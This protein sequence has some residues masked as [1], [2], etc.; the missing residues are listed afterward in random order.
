MPHRTWIC[1]YLPAVISLLLM[2]PST[3]AQFLLPL[4]DNGQFRSNLSPWNPSNGN[5]SVVDPGTDNGRLQ[6]RGGTS[7]WQHVPTTGLSEFQL[8]NCEG[9]KVATGG[10]AGW[11]GI[12][13][14]Y[15][16]AQWGFI[17][18]FEKQLNESGGVDQLGNTKLNPCSLGLRVPPNA[19]HAIIWAANDSANTTTY[20]DNLF[21]FDYFKSYH[22][23]PGPNLNGTYPST[24]TDLYGQNHQLSGLHFWNL[25]GSI[26]TGTGVIGT[27]GAPSSIAQELTLT[28]G[29]SYTIRVYS[30]STRA[31]DAPLVNFGVDYFDA[32]WR[33]IGGQLTT[34]ST[35]DFSNVDTLQAD[36]PA[37]AVHS[38]QWVW[39]DAL[40]A[41][42]G[43]QQFG[44]FF[45]S[46]D[47]VDLTPPVVALKQPVADRTQSDVG[48]QVTYTYTDNTG[49]FPNVDTSRISLV[50]PSGP[51]NYFV[52]WEVVTNSENPLNKTIVISF[53]EFR[54][55]FRPMDWSLLEPGEYIVVASAGAIADANFNEF[56]NEITARFQLIPALSR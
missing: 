22:L 46:V 53:F 25:A 37:D 11:A 19:A 30:D 18:S 26:D 43:Q 36:V 40:T 9:Y 33:R 16:D 47:E 3:K 29:R 48:L 45:I 13:V 34:V 44:P 14:I 54:N 42:I 27:V 51:T 56:P 28:P 31:P 12:G 55:G 10:P 24:V 2:S 1:T 41:N 8:L 20:I 49:S 52:G 50:G 5:A 23:Y 4:S 38:V 32:S 17:D 21:L 7:V 35:I 15:Y 39:V 6:L